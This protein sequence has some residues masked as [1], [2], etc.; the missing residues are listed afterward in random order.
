MNHVAER[1][2]GWKLEEALGRLLHEVF[3]IVNGLTREHVESPVEKVLREGRVVGLAN[4]TILVS[5]DG[6]ER[7]IAD[8]GA[9]R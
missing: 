2:T 4:H 3:N 5:R 7:Q 9:P 8:S 1:L 6:A